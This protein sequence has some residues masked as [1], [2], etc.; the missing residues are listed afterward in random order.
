MKL[1][2]VG[3]SIC[4]G[5]DMGFRSGLIQ[6]LIINYHR[7]IK[8]QN[9]RSNWSYLTYKWFLRDFIVTHGHEPTIQRCEKAK[10][11]HSQTNASYCY[12]IHKNKNR[13]WSH[14]M[15]LVAVFYLAISVSWIFSFNF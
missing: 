7:K 12:Q 4:F 1:K 14:S 5:Y 3:P 8:T 15:A 10:P 11:L 2:P 9:Q 6:Q 13:M